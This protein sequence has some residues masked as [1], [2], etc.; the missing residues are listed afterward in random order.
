M[1]IGTKS[2]LF[3]A[4][5]VFIH[6][7]F[8][9]WGWWKLYG[10]PW[11]PRLWVAFVV[12]DW[13]YWGKPNMDGPEGE[14]HPELGAR[15]MGSLFGK[16]WYFFMR[17]HSRFLAKK[18]DQSFSRLC[19]ADKYAIVLYPVWLYLLQTRWT[20]ESKK[21]M[22]MEKHVEDLGFRHTSVVEWFKHLQNHMRDWALRHREEARTNDSW[23]GMAT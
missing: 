14:Q 13:G 2:L 12:H 6:P 19:C 20:G 15:I 1:N 23:R 16:K 4:H 22:A 21:F 8:V 5:Q 9:A 10:F 11:D 7:W 18:D 17:Y 3:G